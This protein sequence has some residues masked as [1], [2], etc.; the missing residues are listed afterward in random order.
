VAIR[1][2]GTLV[3]CEGDRDTA[4]ILEAATGAEIEEEKP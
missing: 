2:D 4:A 3:V 1:Q